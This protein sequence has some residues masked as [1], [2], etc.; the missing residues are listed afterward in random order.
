MT[1]ND[2]IHRLDSI[3]NHALACPTADP[4]ALQYSSSTAGLINDLKHDILTKG[5][6]QPKPA[7]APAPAKPTT[8]PVNQAIPE[9]AE[10]VK[11]PV[12]V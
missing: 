7:P 10:N 2:L 11:P 3:S 6:E 1:I 8:P 9:G 12:K 5:I 4:N